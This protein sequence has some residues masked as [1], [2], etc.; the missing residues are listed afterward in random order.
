MLSF[1]I[2]S[3]LSSNTLLVLFASLLLLGI[4]WGSYGY[5]QSSQWDNLVHEYIQ[6]STL[7]T[8]PASR[9]LS[10]AVG[11]HPTTNSIPLLKQMD[12]HLEQHEAKKAIAVGMLLLEQDP[13]NHAVLLRLGMVYLQQQQYEE[14]QLHFKQVY[15]AQEPT[16]R[17]LAAWYLALLHAQY[18][19]TQRCKTLLQ[20][21]AAGDAYA[22]QATQLLRLIKA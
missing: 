10:K 22:H 5:Q 8:Q 3:R 7:N 17:P 6:E 14:A 20:E 12:G 1:N 18:G 19:P 4:V 21:V 13:D 9:A 16:S 11:S 2:L 15:Q